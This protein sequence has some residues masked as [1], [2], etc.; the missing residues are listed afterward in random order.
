[1]INF[2]HT[3]PHTVNRLMF[4]NQQLWQQPNPTGS[5]ILRS[6]HGGKESLKKIYLITTVHYVCKLSEGHSAH[7]FE[8]ECVDAIVSQN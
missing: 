7:S 8:P 2:Q 6:A 5:L 1:M 4:P 3:D